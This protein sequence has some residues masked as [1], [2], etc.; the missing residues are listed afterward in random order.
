M[1]KPAALLRA[2]TFN[3]GS[4]YFAGAEGEKKLNAL[5]AESGAELAGLQEVDF[6]NRRHDYDML[7]KFL[8][9]GTFAHGSFQ[10][11]IDFMGGAYGIGTLSKL[12]PLEVTGGA[13][14]YC[15]R[16]EGRAWTRM[17]VQ[18]DGKEIAFYN[19][20]L[21]VEDPAWRAEQ[22]AYL[23]RKLEQDLAPYKI[24]V[25]DL[26][27][28]GGRSE[29]AP[30]LAHFESANGAKGHSF[31][32]FNRQDERMKDYSID[33]IFYSPNIRLRRAEMIETKLSDH[34]LFWAELELL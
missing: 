23:A 2:A 1:D 15:G 34:N 29:L 26:N 8:A 9:E 27:V 31:D 18:K 11:A 5:L 14:P 3:I 30:L 17:L 10:R 21:C 12:Q 4:T 7:G 33:H 25:G 6:C 24:L 19:T 28:D 22:M 20:H 16:Y 32:T 13:L